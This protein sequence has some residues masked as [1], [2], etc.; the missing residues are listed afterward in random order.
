[1]LS[2][3]VNGHIVKAMMFHTCYENDVFPDLVNIE[4]ALQEDI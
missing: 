2:R 1:M 3:H 4:E